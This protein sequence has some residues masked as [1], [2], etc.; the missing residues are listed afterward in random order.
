[1][2]KQTAER[3]TFYRNPQ[4]AAFLMELLK[5]GGEIQAQADTEHGYRYTAIETAFGKSSS[6]AKDLL[7]TLASAGIL[8]EK[9]SDMIIH[10]PACGNA[11]ISTN[12]VC[13]FCGSPRVLRNALVEHIACGYIDTLNVFRA[14]DNLVCPK[15]KAPLN[16]DSY[17]SAG[18]WYECQSCKKRIETPRV[19][20]I[21]RGCGER[22]SFDDA[23][24]VEVY[25]YALSEIAVAEINNGALFLSYA[26]SYLKNANAFEFQEAITGESGIS[27]EFDLVLKTNDENYIAIDHL[28]SMQ[29]ISQA[30]ILSEYG[31]AF[32]SKVKLYIVASQV[33]DEAAKL[34]KNL[35]VTLIV[36][37]LSESLRLLN[38][39][40]GMAPT[41]N[42]EEAN[43]AKQD[44]EA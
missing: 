7:K 8:S 44:A 32:D 37:G 24:Y 15:C 5:G 23:N 36:G 41:T 29:P 11:N 34:A 3:Q 14:Q 10:C 4:V 17:R 30:E 33:T 2:E 35:G 1:M 9:L 28:F 12:Y 22:F 43:I 42:P 19:G 20:H 26:K 13:P 27:H 39:A 25:H 18:R 40:L 21:C 31:K 38:E 6:E 16:K